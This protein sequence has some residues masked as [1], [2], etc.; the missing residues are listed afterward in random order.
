MDKLH[1]YHPLQMKSK[2]KMW[3]DNIVEEIWVGFLQLVDLRQVK[4]LTHKTG[5]NVIYTYGDNLESG[6]TAIT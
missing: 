5:H 1:A 3:P 4:F 6:C 2:A